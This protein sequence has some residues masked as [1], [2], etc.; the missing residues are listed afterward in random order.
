MAFKR[1]TSKTFRADV[2]VPVANE[3]GGY[4]MQT[5]TAV[6]EHATTRELDDLRQLTNAQLIERKLKGWDMEDADTHEQVPFN[7]DTLAAALL[8]PP[9]PMY[10]A[11]SFWEQVN[12][13]RAKNS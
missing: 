2:K 13:A 9:T 5:F 12:G 3:A 4:D 6:W 8:I 11:S 7:Q 1:T 10:L